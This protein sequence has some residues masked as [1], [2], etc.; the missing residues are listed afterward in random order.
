[1]LKMK[2]KSYVVLLE[3]YATIAHVSI[4][5]TYMLLVTFII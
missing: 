4:L 2:R 3:D 1:M 5:Q